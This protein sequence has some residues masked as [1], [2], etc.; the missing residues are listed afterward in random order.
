MFSIGTCTPTYLHTLFLST[1]ELKMDIILPLLERND[2]IPL[3][4]KKL[5][6]HSAF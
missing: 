1:L 4:A 2:H 5:F 3:G 6:Y